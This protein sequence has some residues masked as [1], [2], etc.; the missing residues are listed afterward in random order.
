MATPVSSEEELRESKFAP[1]AIV[2]MA[3][4]LPGGVKTEGDFWDLLLNKN[5]GLCRV[6]ENRY[7]VNGFYHDSKSHFV[8]TKHG[9]FLQDDPA[10]FDTKFFGLSSWE[11]GRLDPQQRLLL[12]VVWEC[13]EGAGQVNKA[14]SV[15]D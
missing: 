6:P 8:K 5:D 10:H 11:A 2:G 15:F 1:I 4:R 7:N 3:M 13:M 9:Y 14:T 12:E